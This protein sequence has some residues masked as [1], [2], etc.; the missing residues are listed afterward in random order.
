MRTNITALVTF[1]EMLR[2]LPDNV[3]Q[4]EVEKR[5]GD[6]TKRVAPTEADYAA[7]TVNAKESDMLAALD[8]GVLDEA[9][10]DRG[11]FGGTSD[12]TIHDAV[13]EIDTAVKTSDMA[14]Y[15]ILMNRLAP[16]AVI[17]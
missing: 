5:E 12:A 2:V 17:L 9:A 15:R 10:A 13:K 4:A 11:M 7:L 8:D 16:N 6:I 14:Y 3:L 1:A